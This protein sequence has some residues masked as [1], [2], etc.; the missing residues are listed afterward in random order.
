MDA[1]IQS[2][3]YFQIQFEDKLYEHIHRGKI[4]I[5][6]VND[7]NRRTEIKEDSEDEDDYEVNVQFK[8]EGCYGYGY[9]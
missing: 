1:Y 3:K 5:M 9:D 2:S 7:I 6:M 4:S 8:S